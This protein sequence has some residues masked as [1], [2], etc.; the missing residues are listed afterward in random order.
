MRDRMKI[1]QNQDSFVTEEYKKH[2]VPLVDVL[3]EKFR[4][5]LLTRLRKHAFFCGFLLF[6]ASARFDVVVSVG[7]R[8]SMTYGLLNRL[9]PRR[10]K[11]HI[12]KEFFFE[13]PTKFSLKKWLSWILYR[14]A[15]KDVTAIVVN[16]AGEVE[17]YA[18]LL[19]LPASR[20]HFIPWPT[21]INNARLV[22]SHEGYIFASGRSL[23]DWETFFEAVAGLER[24]VV[25]VASRADMKH[26]TLPSNV[27]L[28]TD[29]SH[30]QYEKLLIGAMVVVVPLVETQRST[31][32]ASFL[33]AMAYG[34]P[35]VAAKVVGTVDYIEDGNNGMLY[36]AGNSLEL[37]NKI[38]LLCSDTFLRERLSVNAL[39][40]VETRFNKRCYANAMIELAKS[41]LGE[42]R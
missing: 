11:I 2:A 10:G 28:L 25:V 26:R 33:E 3:N 15:L 23:R 19:N 29:I 38:G 42:L 22:P 7:H 31:G 24:R 32:Q 14:F 36:T 13:V 5:E 39:C 16:S 20:F 41:L 9:F 21:N 34:K 12:A 30:E 27:T 8:T 37:R 18:E 35:V 6:I 17:P 40:S 4:C 1:L